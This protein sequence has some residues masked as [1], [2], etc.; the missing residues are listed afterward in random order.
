MAE[1]NQPKKEST[2]EKI[3]EGWIRPMLRETIQNIGL[4]ILAYI[5]LVK[6]SPQGG[7]MMG[8]EGVPPSKEKQTPDWILSAF[9]SL[10]REDD[11]EYMLGL[12]SV[13]SE[14]KKSAKKFRA[15][16]KKEYV[17]DDIKY[18]VNL[19]KARREFMEQLK[20]PA[21]DNKGADR[22]AF[23]KIILKDPIV[24]FFGELLEEER[25]GGTPEEVYER[26]KEDA[27]DRNLLTKIHWLKKYRLEIIIGSIVVPWALLIWLSS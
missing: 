13:S 24:C 15:Q 19:V 6:R 26:Q 3:K 1:N 8:G 23:E 22:L 16:M 2:T 18:V 5:G 7:G 17:Y 27:R 21:P 20:H 4:G 11:N 10:T 9:P 25:L 14:A 12:D